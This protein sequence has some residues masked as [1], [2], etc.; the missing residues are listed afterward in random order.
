MEPNVHTTFSFPNPL[1]QSEELQSWGW[2]E[3][4]ISFLVRFDGHFLPNKQEQQCLPQFE[5][6][7]DGHL[8]L[9]L[10]PAPFRLEM[11]YTT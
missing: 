2:S 6:I 4:L 10:L 9:L 3:T 11:E 8:T 1:S 7:F 5:L